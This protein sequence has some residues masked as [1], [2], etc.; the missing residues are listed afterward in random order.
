MGLRPGDL[1]KDQS[2]EARFRIKDLLHEGRSYYVALGQDTHLD[3]MRVVLKAIRY[4]Q[5]RP[6]GEEIQARR[7]ALRLELEAL[8]LPSPLLPE[9]VDW[10][11]I[12]SDLPAGTQTEPVLVQEFISGRTLRQEVARGDGGLAPARALHM[13]HELALA[14][15]E[16]HE[17]GFVFRDLDPDHVIVGYDDIIHLVGAG[18]MTRAGERPLLY[19]EGVSQ[20]Y[21]APEV[22]SELSGKFLGPRSDIYSL[23]ALL[24]FL[25]TGVD[26]IEQVEAPLD[27]EAYQRLKALPEGYQLLVARC[28]QPMGKN[29]FKNIQALLPWL[30]PQS[31]PTAQSKGFQRQGLPEPFDL[32][33]PDNRATRSKLSGGPLVSE[34]R[35][36]PASPDGAQSEQAITKR[37]DNS[38]QPWYKSCL[39]WL[40]LVALSTS[41]GVSGLAWWLW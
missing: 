23:G 1:L 9:P 30:D 21:S 27:K 10:L 17:R 39:P 12:E 26:P 24:V 38:P 6:S 5:E 34:P 28:I 35:R 37:P 32:N 41:A 13:I 22:R 31:L 2:G 11:E 8:T 19:K 14:L 25:L 7:Q 15:D 40:S 18:N 3:D 36:P 4:S 33:R 20:Q 29:R 16:M